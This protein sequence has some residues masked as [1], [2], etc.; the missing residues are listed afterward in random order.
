MR[1]ALALLAVAF[2]LAAAAEFR[3]IGDAAAVLYDAPS[4][5]ATK[6]YVASR[7][8]PVEVISTDGT[9]V[10][11]RDPFGGLSWLEGKSLSDKRTVMVVVPVAEI[12]Q[13]GEDAAPL[14]FQAQ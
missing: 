7:N 6:V 14:A 5:R 3:S 12:R 2:P 11:V 13:R 1:A 4:A 9:W 10:K 8:L